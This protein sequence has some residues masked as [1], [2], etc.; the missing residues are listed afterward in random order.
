[1]KTE[2]ALGRFTIFTMSPCPHCVNAK[3]LLAREGCDVLERDSFERS[4]LQ[5][6][7]GPVKTLPQIVLDRG[8][9]GVFHI[10]GYTDLV[11]YFNGTGG[12]LRQL[13]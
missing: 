3:L 13:A 11:A 7:V 12:P 2:K 4:E 8:A 10:G 9:D 6:L 1:M 5:A